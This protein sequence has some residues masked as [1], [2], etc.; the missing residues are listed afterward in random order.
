MK[1]KTM[2]WGLLLG[3]FLVG[4]TSQTSQSDPEILEQYRQDEEQF[5]EDNEVIGTM[6]LTKSETFD[7]FHFEGY[8]YDDDAFSLFFSGTVQVPGSTIL[9]KF[10]RNPDT[11]TFSFLI[12]GDQS[13][14]YEF[15]REPILLVPEDGSFCGSYPETFEL[16]SS[17]QRLFSY[18][19]TES[20]ASYSCSL[21]HPGPGS[22]QGEGT[23]LYFTGY[24]SDT[25]NS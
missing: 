24:V 4:C 13:T 1:I 14:Y 3:C 25:Y 11:S 8:R 9:I 5:Y 20:S 7:Y 22:Y 2:F 15:E 12:Q 18:A 19:M 6:K 23:F 10:G 21:D 17:S 16:Q